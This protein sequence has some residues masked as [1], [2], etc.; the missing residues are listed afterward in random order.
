[1][2]R[3]GRTSVREGC[4]QDALNDLQL[5]CHVLDEARDFGDEAIDQLIESGGLPTNAPGR[6]KSV[7]FVSWRDLVN[8]LAGGSELLIH[9]LASGMARRG[10]DV[11]LLCGGP[12][13]PKSHYK[14][15]NAG[16]QFAQYLGAPLQY[17][18]SLRGTELLVEVCNGM[19]F[20][21]PLWRRG[22]TLCFVN[23]VHT[24]QWSQRFGPK[25]ARAGR[26][27]ESDVMPWVH[28]KNL[29]VTISESTRS[30]L[31]AIGIPAD[32]IRVIPQGVEEPPPPAPKSPTPNFVAV[33]RLVGYKRIDLLLDMWKSVR[34]ETGGT[35]T[36]VGDGPGRA[37][38]ESMKIEGVE[39]TGYVSEAEKH[40]LMSQA[41]ILLHPASWEGWGLVITEAAA[42]GTPS[43][44][45][46]VPGV[47]DAIVDFETGFLATDPE[48]FQRHW[49][50]LARDADLRER[51]CEAGKK[52]SSSA[53]WRET[54]SAF[55]QVAAEAVLRRSAQTPTE[56][57]R[58]KRY[59]AKT[60]V[61]G[62]GSPSGVDG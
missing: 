23:H 10:Y 50:H 1:M 15:L 11:S 39:F 38:L 61:N 30:S 7:V 43:V 59:G 2:H 52:R 60:D 45:F 53:P 44:G 51:F 21:T 24:D 49:L 35:L 42:R 4:P 29:I 27:I 40:V 58:A 18:R 54:V 17:L 46:D 9:E 25:V 36:I 19:P 34:A 37:R 6:P 8:P 48:S 41:W 20:L 31:Q 57:Y 16:G 32:H 47:R 22:P 5:G 13:E 26:R 14:I 55:E 62:S 28:R 56:R 3:L 33:G 12:V